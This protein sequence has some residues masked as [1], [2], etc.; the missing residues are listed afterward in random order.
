MNWTT[1]SK[2]YYKNSGNQRNLWFG[3]TMPRTNFSRREFCML[4]G[5][6]IASLAFGSACESIGGSVI[7]SDG[8]LTARPR[9]NVKTSQ[10]GQIMLGVDRERDAILQIPKNAGQSPL[11]LFVMLH[12]ATQNAERMFR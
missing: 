7:A 1:T 9:S 12:G 4:S 2:A 10:T 5:S 11:P 8:R 6:T 3:M